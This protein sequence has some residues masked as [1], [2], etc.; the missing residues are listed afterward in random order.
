MLLYVESPPP[1]TRPPFYLTT[2][3]V[4]DTQILSTS[5]NHRQ[6]QWTSLYM[7]PMDPYEKVFGI[8]TQAMIRCLE[9]SECILIYLGCPGCCLDWLHHLAL[10]PMVRILMSPHLCQHLFLLTFFFCQS[11]M[12]KVIFF[13][14]LIYIS[15]V[16]G[17]VWASFQILPS[18]FSFFSI[19]CLVVLHYLLFYWGAYQFWFAGILRI[20]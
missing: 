16:T 3:L 8:C 19:H 15:L 9:S 1:P 14:I 4:M 12:H 20:F 17:L 11:N 13:V 18:F 5:C 10:S 7:S 2:L 6:I